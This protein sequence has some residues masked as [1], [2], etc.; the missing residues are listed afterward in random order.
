MLNIFLKVDDFKK[1]RIKSFV[2]LFKRETVKQTACKQSV[3][4]AKNMQFTSL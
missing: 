4:N 3:N 1:V 2:S